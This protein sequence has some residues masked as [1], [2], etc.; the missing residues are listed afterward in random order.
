MNTKR[1][2]FIVI[3]HKDYIDED[4]TACI[5]GAVSFSELDN[6]ELI[7]PPDI[8]TDPIYAVE[9]G[10]SISSQNLDGAV[11]FFATWFECPIVMAIIKE[12]SH[13]PLCV[14]G[15][16]SFVYGD[17]E[18]ITGSYV[19]YAMFKGSLDRLNIPYTGILGQIGD[20]YTAGRL[21]AFYTAASAYKRLRRSRAGLVGYTSMSIY[22]GTFDH[23]LM[24]ARIGPE[25]IH[26]DTYTLIRD[27]EKY[28]TDDCKPVMERL[29]G[30][31]RL[32]PCIT[33]EQVLTVSRMY[34][35]LKNLCAEHCLDAINVKCQYELSQSYGMT[36]CVPLSLLADDNIVAACEGD[37]LCTVSMLMLSLLGGGVPAYGDALNHFDNTVRL[38][39][40]G[41]MPYS[42]G[43]AGEC[44]IDRFRH[45][46]FSG[47]KNRFVMRPGKVTVMR[48]IE[49]IGGYHIIYF[50]GDALE[51][52]QLRD[53]MPSV[54][55]RLDGS[56]EK[57]VEHYNGQHYAICYGDLSEEI[58]MLADMLK[59]NAERM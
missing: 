41:I 55:V 12:I 13:I 14:W 38:S 10:I 8:I 11:I 51:E 54:D 44:A 9:A 56:V 19:S 6:V 31:A 29:H 26:I 30:L 21:R 39:P 48:L 49:D 32:H 23:L 58:K 35:A 33:S 45:P 52:S 47:I 27:M 5:N 7:Q 50:T 36:A 17:R 22:P 4:V 20:A 3:A 53:G 1:I 57:F 16:K 40:C 15:V 25:I 59:I 24:C 2:A 28:T 18:L 46:G 37:T 42:L 43:R 34:L